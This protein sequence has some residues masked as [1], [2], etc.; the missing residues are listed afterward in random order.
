[1]LIDLN[2]QSAPVNSTSYDVLIAGAGPAG[3]SLAL[4]LAE[5]GSKVAL[6]EG[7]AKE[8]SQVSQDIYLP[9]NPEATGAFLCYHRLRYLGGTSNHWAGR[10]RPWDAFEFEEKPNLYTET[11]WPIGYDEVQRYLPEARRLL[12]LPA[13]TEFS[14]SDQTAELNSDDFFPDFFLKSPPTRFN[15]RY[16]ETLAASSSIDLYINANLVD[17][18]LTDG[19]RAV[20]HYVVKNYSGVVSHIEAKNYVVA[21]GGI[22]NARMLLNFDSQLEGGL[23]N[24]GDMLG[25]CFME[26]F[27]VQMGKFIPNLS[28]WDGVAKMEYYTSA[29]YSRRNNVGSS[30]ISLSYSGDTQV[31]GR[32]PGLKRYLVDKACG[33][34][35]QDTLRAL[36]DFN[37]PT[38]GVI[39]SLT[40]QFPD[41]N[42]RVALTDKVDALGLRLPDVTWQTNQADRDSIRKIV[43]DFAVQVTESGI[44]RVNL[45]D[46]IVDETLPLHYYPHAHHMGTTRMAE[47]AENGVVDSNCKVFGTDNLFVAGCSVFPR[48]GAN[49]PTMPGVQ[50]ALRLAD[51]L[52][53]RDVET[54]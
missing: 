28:K 36:F 9:G 12:E 1:M 8:Y 50:L 5:G 16:S 38:E 21:M 53:E 26:H 32:L 40:E 31:Y 52:L 47:T 2:T 29:D 41:R 19:L 27:N 14:P 15:S 11:G 46:Y 18:R 6:L 3:I 48:G 30:N 35:K 54:A 33:W 17:I 7:G 43:Q 20:D 49:N 45:P 10:C 25:R 22:E 4:A 34:G 23:G 24:E 39:T 51:H 44:G 42:S 37:C 13:S